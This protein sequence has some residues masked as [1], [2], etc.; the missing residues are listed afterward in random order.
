MQKIHDLNFV[1]SLSLSLSFFLSLSLNSG[2]SAPLPTCIL[3]SDSHS[4]SYNGIL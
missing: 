3:F 4:P 1:L 2:P